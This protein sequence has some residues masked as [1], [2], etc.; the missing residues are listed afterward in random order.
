MPSSRQRALLIAVA[1]ALG[2][3]AAGALGLTGHA[4]AATVCAVVGAVAV[5]AAFIALDRASA[6][7]LPSPNGRAT[8]AS[9]DAAA[10]SKAISLTSASAPASSPSLQLGRYHVDREIGRG[11]MGAVYAAHDPS[12]GL[13]V[14]I[15]TLVIER[16]DE[17]GDEEASA[18]ARARFVREAETARRLQHP[19]IVTVYEAGETNGLAW[20]AMELLQGED[21]NVH[22][23]AGRLLPVEDVLRIVARI[24]LALAHAHAQGIVHRDVKP[25]NVVV[26]LASGRVKVTDFGIARVADSM[27]TRTGMVLGTPLFMAPEQMAGERVDGR[28]DLYAVGVM[29]FQLLTGRLPFEAASLGALMA[30]IANEPA[31]DIRAWRPELPEA[32]AD[33]VQLAL[34]KRPETRYA[35]GHQLADDLRAIE[36]MWRAPVTSDSGEARPGRGHADD[37]RHNSR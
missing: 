32:L 5:V 19:D 20:I 7:A 6:V 10:T 33:V 8:V 29:L 34:Q 30:Q 21:L 4:E 28:S 18:D 11:A 35:D 26:D 24:S 16:V 23:I 14:A 22:T 1:G 12:N 9:N 37:P 2:L 27:R 13:R 3:A 25:A 31:P 15:K 36:A 17:D